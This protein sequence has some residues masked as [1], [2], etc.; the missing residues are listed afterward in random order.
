[1]LGA[2]C[3]GSFQDRFGRRWA[4]ASSSIICA[5]GVA[6]CFVSDIPESAD[7]RRGVFTAGKFVEGSAIGM[8]AATTQTYMSEVLPPALR[9]PV[10]A[11]FPI[12][13]LVGQ[14]LG[15]IAVF[16]SLGYPGHLPFRI[17][18]ASQWPLSAVVLVLA[19]FL[20]ESPVWLLRMGRD[21]M[22]LQC[23]RRLRDGAEAVIADLRETMQHEQESSQ[24]TGYIECFKGVD[25]R[26][27]L[28]VIFASCLPL[29]WGLKL[30]SL[31]SYFIQIVGMSEDLSL[32]MLIAGIVLGIFANIGSLWALKNIG[33]RRLI[34]S[35]LLVAAVFWASIG[36]AG[37]FEG[38][39][40]V[41]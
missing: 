25:R 19:W 24:A 34:I 14:L 37:C 31:V 33:R 41:W 5:A 10:L 28:I 17:P 11:F 15:A 12:F 26:R 40:V 27:T 4:L 20:P 8:M 22:A 13:T 7:A 36:V 16:A 30:L 18:F 39:A 23:Q 1:M 29:I 9:G 3:G 32:I 38:D 2:V 35:T 6:V 21:D